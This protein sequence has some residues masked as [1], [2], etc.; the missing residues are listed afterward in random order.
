MDIDVSRNV[1]DYTVVNGRSSMQTNGFDC[2]VFS[3]MNVEKHLTN[4]PVNH[5]IIQQLMM[6]FRLRIL[7]R[8]LH[9]SIE[10]G[11]VE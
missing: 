8:L 2:G 3:L 1:D 4:R 10:L 11:L 7:N 9:Q 5:P 6:L